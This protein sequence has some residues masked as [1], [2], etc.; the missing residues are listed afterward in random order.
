MDELTT[1]TLNYDSFRKN[2]NIYFG[3]NINDNLASCTMFEVGKL[4]D[5]TILSK[6]TIA[7]LQGL[8]NLA[9][10]IIEEKELEGHWL[11]DKEV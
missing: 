2:D 11:F 5:K 3:I 4:K 1:L 8:I 6:L 7:E 9:K 10:E